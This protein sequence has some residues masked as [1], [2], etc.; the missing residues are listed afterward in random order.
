MA[1]WDGGESITI[2]L[3]ESELIFGIEV[4]FD[5]T[6]DEIDV[7]HNTSFICSQTCLILLYLSFWS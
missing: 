5:T 7:K 3:E 6:I 2:G 4:Y 1:W